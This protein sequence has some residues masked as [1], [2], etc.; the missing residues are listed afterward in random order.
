MFGRKAYLLY[1]TQLVGV[2]LFFG[3]VQNE[4]DN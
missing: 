3:E 2:F 1:G 4:H